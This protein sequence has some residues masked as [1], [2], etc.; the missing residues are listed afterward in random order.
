MENV[1]AQTLE[2]PI[3]LLP[4]ENAEVL[5][6]IETN[7]IEKLKNLA[8]HLN[9]SVMRD[10]IYRGKLGSN[11][12]G[13]VSPGYREERDADHDVHAYDARVIEGYPLL[14]AII[15]KRKEM[16]EA[17]LEA[18]IDPNSSYVLD[19]EYE[20]ENIKGKD[21]S[22]LFYTLPYALNEALHAGDVSIVKTLILHGAVYAPTRPSKEE[23]IAP[24]NDI[25]KKGSPALKTLEKLDSKT[26]KTFVKDCLDFTKISENY[27]LTCSQKEY[28]RLSGTV[29]H[30]LK[31]RESKEI[32]TVGVA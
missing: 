4:N 10:Y 7:D 17:I 9:F 28:E 32:A 8:S 16:V 30:I 18:G 2:L 22:S 13:E 11:L 23:A 1:K 15:N 29:T 6:A 14:H 31:N 3:T 5:N 25:T 27:S 12:K 21:E 20:D 24:L 19:K 26:L